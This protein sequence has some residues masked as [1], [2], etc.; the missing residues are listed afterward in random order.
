[1]ITD[2]PEGSSSCSAGPAPSSPFPGLGGGDRA[3][4]HHFMQQ[5]QVGG[6][7]R[8]KVRQRW[9]QRLGSAQRWRHCVTDTPATPKCVSGGR[10]VRGGGLPVMYGHKPI[11]FFP[12]ENMHSF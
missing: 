11:F 3:D 10:D 4:H 6:S 5:E 7:P 2:S 9:A 12:G 1:M 8:E